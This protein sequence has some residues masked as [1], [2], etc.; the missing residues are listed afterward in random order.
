MLT[1]IETSPLG[2]SWTQITE[3]ADTDHF[4]MSWCLWQS[5]WQ[6]C[7]KPICVAVMEFSSWWC[8]GKVGDEVRDK[9]SADT[10]H[11]SRWL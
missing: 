9:E 3:V 8:T 2:K 4:D 6:V 5:L 10:N 7:D 11:E 1:F